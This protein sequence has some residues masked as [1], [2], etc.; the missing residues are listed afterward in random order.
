MTRCQRCGGN[1]L[2]ERGLYGEPD[3]LACLQCSYSGGPVVPVPVHLDPPPLGYLTCPEPL[4]GVRILGLEGLSRHHRDVH[5][6]RAVNQ[7]GSEES[8]RVGQFGAGTR[9]VFGKWRKHL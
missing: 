6:G 1:L 9:V 8:T 4:C 3:S 7:R 2:R 5:E